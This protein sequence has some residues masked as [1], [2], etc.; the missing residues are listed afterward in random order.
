MCNIQTIVGATEST[1]DFVKGEGT[2]MDIGE[3]IIEGELGPIMDMMELVG[4]LLEGEA[5]S[6]AEASTKSG[7]ETT[8]MNLGEGP[9]TINV[10]ANASATADAEDESSAL[11]VSGD[12]STKDVE[13]TETDY[14]AGSPDGPN[15][16]ET[17]GE[18]G[19]EADPINSEIEGMKE[20]I[21][22]GLM[23]LEELEPG[24][25]D[26][27]IGQVEAG[28][29]ASADAESNAGAADRAMGNGSTQD[30]DTAQ[31]SGE[32]DAGEA[33]GDNEE[34][35]A[36][37]EELAV[38]LEDLIGQLEGEEA[39][40]PAAGEANSEPVKNAA[41]IKD[42][43]PNPEPEDVAAGMA[44]ELGDG[45]APEA[46]Q[47]NPVDTF[48]EIFDQ[49]SPDAQN[50]VV[51]ILASGAFGKEGLEA[52]DAVIDGATGEIDADNAVDEA[53]AA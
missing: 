28:A 3:S 35:L 11:S 10:T 17:V 39:D 40:Q 9:I 37:L 16:G 49:M 48:M 8:S 29:G 31:P 26:D 14:G 1:V 19:E 13:G 18:A 43:V 30:K 21:A 53:E 47:S 52:A 50:E 4:G 46:A 22:D 41:D 12:Q 2:L 51:E 44:E 33:D 5:E 6:S 36:S 25:I 32:A 24:F 27:V 45:Q 42:N 15:E 7:A 34:L 20:G 23:A 38:M